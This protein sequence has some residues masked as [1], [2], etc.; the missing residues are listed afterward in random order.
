MLRLDLGPIAQLR[1]GRLT[2]RLVQLMLGLTLYGISMA[3][4]VRGAVG[5]LPWDVLHLGIAAH[6]PLALGTVVILTSLAVLLGWLPLRQAPGLGT[7]L[8]AVWI[9][10]VL[11]EV[12]PLLHTPDHLGGR[13]ALMLGGVVLNAV[14]TAAYIGAQLGPGPRDG[15][16]TGLS[17]RTGLSLRLVRTALE[18]F[19]VGV[20]WALGGGIGVGTLVYAVSIGPL[21]QLFLR[22]FAVELAVPPR[23]A[24]GEI[25]AP[26]S[27]PGATSATPGQTAYNA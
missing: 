3:M 8:N 11:N 9:G 7:L 19:V 17:R 15:L 21:T 10:L 20:G 16:M 2:R 1:A 14:A 12:L 6:V 23:N 24:D 27:T 5:V 4:V 13:V 22:W 25:L 18:L 26:G